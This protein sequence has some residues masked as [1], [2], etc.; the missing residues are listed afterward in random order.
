MN[1]SGAHVQSPAINPEP[2]SRASSGTNSRLSN[3]G[4]VLLLSGLC[5]F[6]FLYRLGERDL[7]SSHEGR[8]AQDAQMILAEKDWGLPRLFDQQ[9]ELQKP[10]LYYWLVALAALSRGGQVD[11]WAVRLPAAVAAIAGIFGLYFFCFRRRRPLAGFIA[12]LVLATA[13]HYTWLGRTGRIDMPLTLAITVSLGGFYLG[14]CSQREHKKRTWGWF[15]LSYLAV[16]FAVLLKGP[17]GIV[18]PGSVVIVYLL[19]EGDLPAPWRIGA[20]SQK[21]YQFGLWWGIPLVAGLTVPWFVWANLQTHGSLFDKFF[22]YHNVERAFGGSGGLR[23]HPWYLYGPYLATNML[24]WT[25]LLPVAVWYLWRRRDAWIDTEA[26]FGLAWLLT[27][28]GVLSLFRFKRADYLLPA[29]PGAALFLGCVAER[30]YQSSL[31]R[32]RLSVGLATVLAGCLIGW[33]VY[34]DVLLPG[35]EPA[36]EYKRFAAEIRRHAPAPALVLFFRAEAHALAF[37]VGYPINTFLEW[38]NL[39]IWAGR[40]GNHFIVM[41]AECAAE[42]PRHVTSGRLEEVLRST[43]LEGAGRRERPLVLMRTCPGTTP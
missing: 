3:C 4:F 8:A 30:W 13:I 26:K 24:P 33:W 22:W 15:L 9:L 7:W 31:H 12:A 32:R 6:L 37:H 27:M 40:P 18:L 34:L 39:D 43:D 28:A 29:M 11:S 14:R 42:W 5:G 19:M 16:A 21:F 17:I 25:P 41:P 36:R 2:L 35:K 1:Q 10:P 38:E 23:A 20:V